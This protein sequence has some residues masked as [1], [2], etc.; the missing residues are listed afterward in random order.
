MVK[1]F[2]NP[3]KDCVNEKVAYFSSSNTIGSAFSAYFIIP[4]MT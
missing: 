2:V 4:T 3:A 1:F